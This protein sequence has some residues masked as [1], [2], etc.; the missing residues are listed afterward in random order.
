MR[1]AYVR[2]PNLNA[3]EL[4]NV[5]GLAHEVVAFASFAGRYELGGGIEVRRL[6]CLR[7]PIVR[8]PAIVGAAVHRFAGNADYVF[9]LERALRGFDVA[10]V[11]DLSFPYSLQAVRARDAGA[12]GRVI[13]TVWENIAFPPWENGLVARR[14]QKVAAGVDHCI[15]ISEDARLH[16]EVNGVPED[17][18]TVLPPGIDVERFRPAAE[19][20][21]SEPAG[22]D[23]RHPLRILCVSRLV[24]EKGVDDVV[25]AAGLLRRRGIEVRVKLV[26]AGPLAPRLPEMAR[27]MG[28][29]DAVELAGSV[30]YAD[31]PDTYRAADVFVLA[32]GPRTTWREQF[33]FAV[34]EAMASGLPVVAGHSGSLAE[35]V[36]DPDSLVVPHEPALLADKLARLAAGPDLRRR[37]GERNR[38]WAEE[39]YDRRDVA[40]RLGE[41]YE[42]VAARPAR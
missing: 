40:R 23:G 17:R 20:P 41:L 25:V 27:R 11:A 4:Q 10:H 28:V 34:V 37:Q 19:G 32:S 26:G 36:G 5:D 6:P 22:G 7:D 24:E 39:R 13:A 12:C 15:A 33:G 14:V 29:E 3:W 42:A 38:R 21:A 9:G 35:V 8:A 2:G 16:L 18:I 31:L 1:I 30:S